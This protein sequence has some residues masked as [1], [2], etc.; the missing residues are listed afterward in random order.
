MRLVG[1][2]VRGR[3]SGW[4]DEAIQKVE[5]SRK[6]LEKRDGWAVGGLAGVSTIERDIPITEKN[7]MGISKYRQG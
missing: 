5:R 1:M 4:K 3:S 6:R 7:G 2:E